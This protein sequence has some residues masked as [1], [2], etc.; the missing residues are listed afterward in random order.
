[1][2][3]II[4]IISFFL[5]FALSGCAKHRIDTD[6]TITISL[7]EKT[8]QVGTPIPVQIHISKGGSTPS[9]LSAFIRKGIATLSLNG[10]ALEPSGQWTPIQD[11]PQ[12]IIT[13]EMPGDLV[14]CFRVKTAEG[15]SEMQDLH[16]TISPAQQIEVKAIYDSLIVNL[17]ESEKIPIKIQFEE[18]VER[19]TIT[20]TLSQGEGNIYYRDYIIND[21]EYEYSG[22]GE[23]T[24]R[25]DPKIIGEHILEFNVSTDKGEAKVRVYFSVEKNI[26]AKSPVEGCFSFNG[27]GRYNT[28]GEVVTLELKNDPLFNFEVAGWYNEAGQLLSTEPSYPVKITRRGMASFTVKLK[29]RT[30]NI[31]RGEI[32]T[33]EFIYVVQQNGKPVV[34]KAYDYQTQYIGDYRASDKLTFFYEEFR[35]NKHRLPPTGEKRERLATMNKGESRSTYLY[36]CDRTFRTYLRAK[37]NPN[38]QFNYAYRYVE[39]ESTRYVIPHDITME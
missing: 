3:F 38:L 26:I 27:I 21:S 7:D 10:T 17:E 29:P 22:S 20:P 2:T 8:G 6:P 34:K 11:N 5:F 39:S 9:E 19:C 1:M 33:L 36:R 4:K 24:F 31:S 32:K 25:Y 15:I 16:L 12:I 13:P 37:D 14:V 28:E 18:F 30:V 23:I 35:L